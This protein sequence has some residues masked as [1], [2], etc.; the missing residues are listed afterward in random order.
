MTAT[1]TRHDTP[2]SAAELAGAREVLGRLESAF[3]ESVVGQP[4][5]R[6]SLLVALLAGGHILLESLPG[7]A[8]TTAANTLATLA[9]STFAR[10]QCTPDLLPTDITGTQVYDAR[11]GEFRT[12]LGPVHANV[13]LL[14]EINRSSAKTQAAMLEAMQERRVT[15]G[16]HTHALPSPFLVIATQNPIEQEG[17]Y[18]L[19]EAQLDR[20]LLKELIDYPSAPDELAMLRG[21]TD[22]TLRDPAAAA[23]VLDVTTVRRLQDV[24]ARIHVSDAV[25]RYALTIVA[26]TR[27]A[28]TYIGADR[29]RYVEC[30][31]SPRAGIAFV[32][33]ARAL[34]VLE[35]RDHVLPEDVRELRHVVLRH[36]VL[37]HFDADVDGV[38]AEDLIDAIVDSVTAP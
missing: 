11:T 31:A 15:I 30:G 1:T 12:Q 29:A 5:L 38:R 16:G 14:D 4:G 19:P 34:A 9:G 25:L 24:A 22:R 23:P 2:T 27:D 35:G 37:L 21:F 7:L 20:F 6:R 33:A 18:P 13:V 17:T 36:R 10:I 26:A 3:G 28:A 8:K 32:T